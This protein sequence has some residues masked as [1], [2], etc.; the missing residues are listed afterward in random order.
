MEQT[1]L[2]VKIMARIE[3]EKKLRVFKRK[4]MA[5][6]AMFIS[7]MAFSVPVWQAF[8]TDITQSGF[9][10]FAKLAFLDFRLIMTNW[11]DFSLSLLESLPVVSTVG[12]LLSVSFVII[13]LNKVMKYGHLV[14]TP[15]LKNHI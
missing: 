1:E 5:L 8:W 3:A 10:Q 11:Y 13:T 6:G 4:L 9:T 7:I 12:V 15:S 2:L 14:F